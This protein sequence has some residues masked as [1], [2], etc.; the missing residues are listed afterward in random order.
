MAS[1]LVVYADEYSETGASP[2]VLFFYDAGGIDSGNLLASVAYETNFQQ[3]L[4][5]YVTANYTEDTSG[6][7]IGYFSRQHP[8]VVALAPDGRCYAASAPVSVA[9]ETPTG[10]FVEYQLDFFRVYRPDGHRLPFPQLH[11]AR[12]RAITLDSAGN[13]YVG[14]DTLDETD[15]FVGGKYDASGALLWRMIGSPRAPESEYSGGRRDR[16]YCLAL[17]SSGNLYTAGGNDDEYGVLKKY[18][19]SGVVQWTRHP[20]QIIKSL[21]VDS[22]GFLYTAFPDQNGAYGEFSGGVTYDHFVSFTTEDTFFRVVKWDADGNFVAGLALSSLSG[23]CNLFAGVDQ[24]EVV[25]RDASGLFR[26][27]NSYGYDLSLVTTQTYTQMM[28]AVAPDG[29]VYPNPLAPSGAYTPEGGL[30]VAVVETG[31]VMSLALPV[32]LGSVITLGDRYVAVPALALQIGI[33]QPLITLDYTGAAAAVYRLYLTGGSGTIELSLASLQ[34]RR[35]AAS[36]W[37]SV[38]V[39]SPTP[40]ILTAIEDRADGDLIVM[41]GVRFPDGTE[42]TESFFRAAYTALRYDL[43]GRSAS[44]TLEATEAGAVSTGYTRPARAISYRAAAKGRRRVRCAVDT[45]LRPGDLLDLGGGETLIVGGLTY[46]IN[47][48]SAVMEVSEIA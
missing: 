29:T 4:S 24:L 28:L 48:H 13:L 15:H 38:V 39:P 40:A 26:Y 20:N 8:S 18:N 11:G 14:G 6:H 46:Q 1:N 44:L 23:W 10:F 9:P 12:I 43:G 27:W 34:V 25:W 42:Q 2:P 35:N 47:P 17:D 37:L 41:R 32:Q 16:I 19:A 33:A 36:T 7:L 5:N 22:S 21:V 45:Y 31:Q 3:P 30:N